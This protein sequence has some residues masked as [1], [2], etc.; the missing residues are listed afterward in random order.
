MAIRPGGNTAL[1]LLLRWN[2]D[3]APPALLLRLSTPPP[4]PPL[5][6]DVSAADVAVASPKLLLA[7]VGVYAA[8]AGGVA[9][10]GLAPVTPPDTLVVW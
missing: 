8:D 10:P 7:A 1:M 3:P 6:A 2:A 9:Q 4:L 5:L